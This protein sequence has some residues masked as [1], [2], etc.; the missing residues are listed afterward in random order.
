MHPYYG[1]T[2][3]YGASPTPIESV[4]D[5]ENEMN[6]APAPPS[7]VSIT[8]D[9]GN[10]VVNAPAPNHP[11]YGN[12]PGPGPL[13]MPDVVPILTQN[14]AQIWDL[15]IQPRSQ[16][17]AS[18]SYY[19]QFQPTPVAVSSQTQHQPQPYSYAGR[20]VQSV[21]VQPMPVPTSTHCVQF[22]SPSIT[23]S[24]TSQAMTSYSHTPV[25]F[26]FSSPTFSC[27]P[28]QMIAP[29]TESRRQPWHLT[30]PTSMP[31]ASPGPPEN[32]NIQF[33]GVSEEANC[34]PSITRYVCAVFFVWS[35]FIR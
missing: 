9:L 15:D 20:P 34:T 16:P 5:Q 35:I 3:L 17:I 12:T 13:D 28:V 8:P 6:A 21:N 23:N 18:S 22:I 7:G 31:W 29:K 26:H 27:P 1:S 14:P 11:L 25:S 32:R 10:G 30:V 33:T 2:S 24:Y 4:E 19:P